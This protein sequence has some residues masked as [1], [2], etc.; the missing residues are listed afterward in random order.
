MFELLKLPMALSLAVEHDLSA[1]EAQPGRFTYS[2][3]FAPKE[4][5]AAGLP[6]RCMHP[7][8][9]S[10]QES[11]PRAH[12]QHWHPARHHEQSRALCGATSGVEMMG[13]LLLLPELAQAAARAAAQVA[14]RCR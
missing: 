8:P 13:K 12:A 7:L 4:G 1:G 6:C 3:L 5:A 11:R 9:L 14:S 10:F 2:L